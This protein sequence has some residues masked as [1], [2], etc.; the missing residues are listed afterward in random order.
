VPF[1]PLPCRTVRLALIKLGFTEVKCNSGTSHEQW[2]K[3]ADGR[4][5]KVTV[6]CHRGEVRALDV[7]SI[8][9]QAGVSKREFGRL[10]E[11]L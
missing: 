5:F 6:D 7:K 3:V 1:K 11:S 2:E 9:A 8:I 10:I 4:K